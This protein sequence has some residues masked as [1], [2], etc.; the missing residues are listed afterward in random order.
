MTATSAPTRPSGAPSRNETPRDV[1]DPARTEA[2]AGR[3]LQTYTEGMVGLMVDLASRTGLLETLADRPGTS[4]ELAERAGLTERYVRECLGSLVTAG[5]ACYDA[6]T[7]GYD[8]P[9][10]HAACLAGE[11]SQNL[12]PLARVGTLL[13]HHLDGVARAFRE[14]GGVPYE[15]FR[16]EF[17]ETMDGIS[18][19]TFDAQLVDALV[20]LAEELPAR[21][22]RGVAAIDIGCGTGHSTNV[23]ARAFP[24]STFVGYDLSEEALERG[25]AEAADWRLDNVRFEPLDL[26]ELAPDRPADVIFAFDVI[27]DQADP[28]TVLDRVRA[29]LADDGVF[30][31]MDIKASSNLEDN[32]DNPL[33]PLLY[34]ISTLHC[35][36]VSLA[37]DGAGL[38]TVWGEELAR[39]MLADAGFSRVE[40]H[41]VPDDPLDSVY[42][43][44][45]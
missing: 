11:G 14:G 28:V 21:L 22:A 23:L 41:D 36:T 8:L 42:V 27:H 5:I 31:M 32:L 43:A 26:V 29:A 17:T 1:P 19:G 39:R 18:R 3:L 2:F 40:V 7:A 4:Q 38:G 25:R 30:V 35:M 33:A 16:P 10:E 34:G 45:P 20:P 24:R 13:A 9:S 15:A 37:R 44:R 6:E 12:A